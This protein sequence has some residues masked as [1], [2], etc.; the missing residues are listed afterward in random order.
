L[1]PLRFIEAGESTGRFED[2]ATKPAMRLQPVLPDRITDM[3]VSLTVQYSLIVMLLSMPCHPPHYSAFCEVAR[4][5]SQSYEFH[6]SRFNN[7]LLDLPYETRN[8][9]SAFTSH[10]HLLLAE[11]DWILRWFFTGIGASARL[12]VVTLEMTDMPPFDDDTQRLL[13]RRAWKGVSDDHLAE[14]AVQEAYQRLLAKHSED[15]IRQDPAR[16]TGWL[17]ISVDNVCYELIRKRLPCDG[18]ALSEQPDNAEGPAELAMAK[19]SRERLREAIYSLPPRQ[20]EVFNLALEGMLPAEIAATLGL[21][22]DAVHQ[23]ISRARRALRK[24][25]RELREK[26][27]EDG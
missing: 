19:E 17:H 27:A 13:R 24:K 20:A 1:R 12:R 11:V 23:H 10:P 22:V 7:S 2:A 9:L 15:E 8:S 26:E 6:R 14:E 25:L 5:P 16:F 4:L 18:G 21:S 3:Y